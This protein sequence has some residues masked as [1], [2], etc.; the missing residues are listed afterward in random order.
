[1]SGRGPIRRLALRALAPA[2]K[3]WYAWWNG[4]ERHVRA[5]GFDLVVL[6][7]V[8]HPD[9]FFSTRLLAEHLKAI[10]LE[11][12]TF[13]D[14]GT[15]SGRIALTAARAGAS[16]TASDLNP[17]ALDTAER[18]AAKNG[19]RI[20][21]VLSDQFEALPGRFDVIAIN[22]PYYDHEPANPA[23][24]AFHAG[25]G[26]RYFKRLFPALAGRLGQ[27]TEVFMV[28]SEDLDLSRIRSIA[29]DCG[30][31]MHAVL[32]KRRWAETSTVFA[33]TTV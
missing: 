22:P 27:G 24:H 14:L 28:L 33:I 16:V 4:K 29:K 11:G 19:L 23:E 2:L 20:T 32:S 9:L 13:L 17:A 18:N 5:D 30:L 12:R 7:G 8:F 1:M 15:G 25:A 6:P 3:S 21:T 10:P 26:L 31:G